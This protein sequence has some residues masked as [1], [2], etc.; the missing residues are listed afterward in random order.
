MEIA[1]KSEFLLAYLLMTLGIIGV[2]LPFLPGAPLIWLGALVWAWG[3]GFQRVGWPTLTVLGLLMIVALGSDWIMTTFTTR[4][5]GASW[6]ATMAALVGGVTGGIA[7]TILPV[8]GTIL[9]TFLGATAGVLI[10][11][12]VGKRD[13]RLATRSAVG[14]TL[15]LL[16][17]SVLQMILCLLMVALFAWQAFF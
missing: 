14:Y 17:S 8:L 4:K 3:D 12:Y 15:G 16:A 9:G 6:K 1:V 2:V 7:F 13:W 10:V 5:A 11:E